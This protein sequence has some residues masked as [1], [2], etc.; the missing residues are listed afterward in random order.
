L[1]QVLCDIFDVS[2]MTLTNDYVNRC[3]EKSL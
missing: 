2:A 1:A 3:R